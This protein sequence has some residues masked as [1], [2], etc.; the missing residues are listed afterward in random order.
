MRFKSLADWLE[1]QESFHPKAIDLG[2]ERVKSVYQAL[3]PQGPKPYTITIAGTNGKG[4]CVAML[5]E[6]FCRQGFRVGAYTSPH[7]LRYNERIQI[8]QTLVNDD[9]ICTAFERV[10]QARGEISL[11]YFEFGTL[12]ALDIFSRSKL[13]I[14]L[15]EVGL[16]GR[17]DAVNIIDADIAVVTCIEIDHSDWL[18]ESR[19]SIGLEK[20]GIFRRALPAII[21]DIN[22]PKSLMESASRKKAPVYSL[23]KEFNYR[24]H[25]DHWDWQGQDVE[26][27]Q[28]PL[29]SLVGDQQ[30]TNASI[31]LQAI[32]LAKDI[33][34]VSD[35]SIRSGL[36]NVSLTGR[37]QLIADGNR[38]VLLDVAHN[39]HAVRALA[40]S[41]RKVF[42]DRKMV[43]IF[44][45]MSN[46]DIEGVLAELQKQIVGWY[47]FSLDMSRAASE[48]KI[49]QA[50]NNCSISKYRYGFE[51]FQD[52]LKAAK[53]ES[54]ED[55]LIV[56]FGSFFLAAKYLGQHPNA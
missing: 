16:G 41:L 3:P 49:I 11:S 34:P 18:G 15:L 22:P 8:N 6:I 37:F 50:F 32:Q 10:D 23:G 53:D 33:R 4:S 21:G 43:A 31:V 55:D 30:L 29:P 13:D 25:S 26:L 47:I 39:P 40:D 54:G 12:A 42:P 52:V 20:A 28:L 38:Q 51:N 14:Q 7:L 5:N 24:P 19:E 2:L 27:K 1:W 48:A 46:K 35:E 9:D 17:L 56:I 44:S 36:S 45:I